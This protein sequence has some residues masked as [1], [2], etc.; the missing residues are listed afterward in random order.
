MT[1]INLM[2]GCLMICATVVGIYWTW[3]NYRRY[4][5]N[6]QV[7]TQ[8]DILLQAAIKVSQATQKVAKHQ[9]EIALTDLYNPT[10]AAASDIESPALLSTLLAVIVSKYGDLKLSMKDFIIPSEEYVSVYVDTVSQELILSTK[11]ELDDL[12]ATSLINIS[13]PDDTTYH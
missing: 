11:H 4:K 10:D 3:A 8:L 13:D 7:G 1:T 12:T 6:M 5:H 9:K 2:L